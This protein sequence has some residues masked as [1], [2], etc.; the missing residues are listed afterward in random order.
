MGTIGECEMDYLI[1]IPI[2]FVLIM[3]FGFGVIVGI[4]NYDKL[5]KEAIERDYAQYNPKT[6]KWEWK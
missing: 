1:V 2:I 4:K 6:G 3:V 5:I